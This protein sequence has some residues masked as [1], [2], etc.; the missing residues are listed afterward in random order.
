MNRENLKKI[1]KIAPTIDKSINN[2][3]KS[4]AD[5]LF[6]NKPILKEITGFDR[7]LNILAVLAVTLTV[8]TVLFKV[9]YKWD[10]FDLDIAINIATRFFR[11]DLVTNAKKIEMFYSLANTL[12]LSFMSTLT[13]FVSGIF[14]ALFAARNISNRFLS[15]A[16]RGFAGLIRAVPTIIW[17]LIF[18]SGYG[19]SS[20]TAVVGMFF[21]TLSFFIRSLAESFE[22]VDSATIE[23]LN[24]AGANK[25]QVITGAIIPSSLTRIISWF[26]LRFEQDFGTAVI[27]GPAVGVP[28]TIGTLI[29]NAARVGD[30]SSQGFGVLLVFLTA[31]IMEV[32]MN[33]IREK[34][35]IN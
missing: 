18:V 31:F 33:K 7:F 34:N 12:A 24:A 17:V 27:I 3:L 32:V 15:E 6:T 4:I 25:L 10:F 19:L 22:E 2:D 28:G 16:I 11:V 9:E 20:T 23:A 29:N 35:L 14:M 21:H 5:K 1:K 8:Y 30:Y 26:A 13:G